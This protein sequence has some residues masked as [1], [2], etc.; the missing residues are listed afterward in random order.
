MG[1][2][3]GYTVIS[4]PVIATANP[5]GAMVAHAAMHLAAVTH[6]YE[7]KDRLPPQVFVG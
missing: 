1:P 7:N 4:L 2:V 3:L 5:I 6:A